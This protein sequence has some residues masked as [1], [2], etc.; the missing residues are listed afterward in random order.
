MCDI[1]YVLPKNSFLPFP[2]LRQ[3][4]SAVGGAILPTK[5]VRRNVFRFLKVMI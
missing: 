1:I 4:C 3:A 2:F 5:D